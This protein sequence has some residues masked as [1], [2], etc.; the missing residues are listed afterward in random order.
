M[1]DWI[2]VLF[3]PLDRYLKG[4]KPALQPD[5]TGQREPDIWYGPRLRPKPCPVCGFYVYAWEDFDGDAH[6]KH[7][8]GV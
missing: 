8:K 5:R 1:K 3:E 7:K 4:G 6:L 2:D